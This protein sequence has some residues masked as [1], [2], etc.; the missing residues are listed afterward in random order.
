MGQLFMTSQ[1][2]QTFRH[3]ESLNIDNDDSDDDSETDSSN[4][5]NEHNDDDANK[6]QLKYSRIWMFCLQTLLLLLHQ[7]F[8]IRVSSMSCKSSPLSRKLSLQH[9]YIRCDRCSSM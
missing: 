1:G 3:E 6:R 9:F 4:G 8:K 5:N 2:A 7:L